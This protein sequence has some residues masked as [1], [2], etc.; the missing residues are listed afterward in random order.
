M[1]EVQMKRFAFELTFIS[2]ISPD[3]KDIKMVPD[4]LNKKLQSNEWADS[5]FELTPLSISNK[6]YI[7][8]GFNSYVVKL[9]AQ[10]P[11]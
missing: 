8:S 5:S 7:A 4:E 10:K 11:C 2:Q 6:T 9:K 3:G 1:V